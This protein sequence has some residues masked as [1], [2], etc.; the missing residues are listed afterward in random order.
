MKKKKGRSSMKSSIYSKIMV[1]TDGSEPARR[2]VDSAIGIAKLS[3]AKLYAVHVI[4]LGFYSTTHS[5]D[6][7][8]EKAMKEQLVKEGKEVT[9][10][11]EN[12]GRAKNVEVES[13]ILEGNPAEEIIDFAERNDID[14]VVMGTHGITGITRV[15]LGSV[16]ENVVRHS[17]KA[18]LV[19]RGE[20]AENK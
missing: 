2:A 11:V 19:V 7:E 13:A 16:A 6:S 1:A 15:L 8:W 18:V 4:A 10:Y 5:T 17:K 20:T 12:A 3:E 9:D 14:L